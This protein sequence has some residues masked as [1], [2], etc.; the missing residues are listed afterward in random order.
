MY[1]YEQ[2]NKKESTSKTETI[3]RGQTN[4]QPEATER[5]TQRRRLYSQRE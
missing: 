4:R 5:S 1:I 3:E 2:I